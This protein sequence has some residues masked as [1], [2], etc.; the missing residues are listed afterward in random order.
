MNIISYLI[1]NP[2]FIIIGFVLFLL[3][4]VFFRFLYVRYLINRCIIFFDNKKIFNRTLEKLK[5]I[6]ALNKSLIKLQFQHFLASDRK[7]KALHFMQILI[8]LNMIK[9]DYE[10]LFHQTQ[11]AKILFVDLNQ[12]TAA[13]NKLYSVKEKGYYSYQWNLIMCDIFLSQSRYETANKYCN[14]ALKLD[15][16]DRNIHKRKAVIDMIMYPKT[17]KYTLLEKKGFFKDL[18]FDFFLIINHLANEHYEKS[19]KSIDYLLNKNIRMFYKMYLLL[20]K[21]YCLYK[22]EKDYYSTWK[23]L[24]LFINNYLYAETN[25]IALYRLKEDLL[26]FCKFIN[27]TKSIEQ[28]E[29]LFVKAGLVKRKFEGNSLDKFSKYLGNKFEKKIKQKSF[30]LIFLNLY[31]KKILNLKPYIAKSEF[32]PMFEVKERASNRKSM[33][34]KLNRLSKKGLKNI[35]E[36]ISKLLGYEV[37]STKYIGKTK[38]GAE[39]INIKAL[40]RYPKYH[41]VLLVFRKFKQYS[42]TNDYVDYLNNL[43]TESGADKILLI[44]NIDFDTDILRYQEK[45]DKVVFYDSKRTGFLLESL[46]NK[47]KVA[48]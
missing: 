1:Q 39:G 10:L 47:K 25:K 30:S 13:F 29:Q 36:K 23:S 26:D 16:Q 12:T 35:G 15:D 38:Y 41:Y 8:E 7:E 9:D 33:M 32:S 18:E 43:R 4:L 45:Y 14:Q 28:F 21:T 17:A 5:K 19:I 22:L 48:S 46:I 37:K 40:G 44:A 11:M 20:F 6:E 34:R 31:N 42:L 3:L 2:Y 27:D 24:F